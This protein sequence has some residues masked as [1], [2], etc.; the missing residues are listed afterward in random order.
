MVTG[1]LKAGHQ[2]LL[3]Y[4]E[5][6]KICSVEVF[7]RKPPNGVDALLSEQG[8]GL[9]DARDVQEADLCRFR[10]VPF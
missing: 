10:E 4:G 8:I 2:S 9:V 5:L 3:K 6:H 1:R 7:F